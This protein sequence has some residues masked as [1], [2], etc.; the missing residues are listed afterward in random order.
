MLYFGIAITVFFAT[1][2]MMVREGLW[3]NVITLLCIVL[4]GLAAFGLYQPLTVWADEH[5]GWFDETKEGSFTYLLDIVVLWGVYVVAMVLL[6]ELAALLSKTRMRFKNPIDP[7]GGPILALLAAWVMTAFTMATLHTA[8]L[9][10]DTLGG[11]LLHDDV[12]NDSSLGAPDLWWLRFVEK[13]SSSEFLGADDANKFSANGFVTTYASHRD[14]FN[15]T[16]TWLIP[17]N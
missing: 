15:N 17:R 4:S 8:P 10:K 6:R 5:S 14:A 13:V 1:L 3:S 12:A 16:D 9:A 11:R 2:A 7:V